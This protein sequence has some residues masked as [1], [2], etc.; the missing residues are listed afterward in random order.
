MK[1][2]FTLLLL[3]SLAN[4]S[5]FKTNPE[6]L[7][8]QSGKTA[9]YDGKV[10]KIND[11]AKHTIYFSDRPYRLAGH[12]KNSDLLKIWSDSKQKNSF[13][14]D[15]PNAAISYYDENG[16]PGVAIIE[17]SNLKTGKNSISYDVKIIKG[18]LLKHMRE[19]SLFI[20]SIIVTITVVPSSNASTIT[21]AA[22]L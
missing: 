13:K 10:L 14:K 7:F 16:K 6:L 15:N 9:I 20:D 11:A 18:S 21:P 3:I 4:C 22:L 8:A 1:K 5:H 17:L 2:L 19:V 12:I